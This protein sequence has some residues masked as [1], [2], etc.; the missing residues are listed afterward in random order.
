MLLLWHL[1]AGCNC[2]HVR[3][4]GACLALLLAYTT[5]EAHL[6][7][8]AIPAMQ[9]APSPVTLV[10][11]KGENTTVDVKASCCMLRTW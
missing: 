1:H 2:L 3:Q 11:V 6:S 10:V 8:L 9:A 5:T 4:D 7:F